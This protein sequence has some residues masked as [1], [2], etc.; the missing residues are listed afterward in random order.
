MQQIAAAKASAIGRY[1][2]LDGIEGF[3]IGD[4]A[5]RVYIRSDDMRARLPAQVDGV[6]IEFVVTGNIV[7]GAR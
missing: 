1:A 2:N 5:L 3:G 7:A 6:P 4:G